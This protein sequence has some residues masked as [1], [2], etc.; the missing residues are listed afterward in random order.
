MNYRSRIEVDG[1]PARLLRLEEA[2]FTEFSEYFG[3]QFRRKFLRAGLSPVDA[4]DLAVTCVEDICLKVKAYRQ[5]ES[6]SFSS[7]VFSI[8]RRNLADWQTKSISFQDCLK[9]LSQ[10]PIPAQTARP[11]EGLFEAVHEALSTLS[12]Q[13]QQI[14]ELRHLGEERTYKEIGEILHITV[15]AAR[16]R[17]KRALD[18]LRPVLEPCPLIQS[19][20]RRRRVE[21]QER[22]HTNE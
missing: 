11:R 9:L 7:W 3:P 14:I 4:E 21:P 5:M 16:V 22:W 10:S 8:A 2:A 15:G 12:A 6:A 19:I 20:T 13:E 17:H 18:R 1:L